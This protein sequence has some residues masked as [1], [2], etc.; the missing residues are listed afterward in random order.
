MRCSI[1]AYVLFNQV[2]ENQIVDNR[3]DFYL[4]INFIADHFDV[5]GYLVICDGTSYPYPIKNFDREYNKKEMEKFSHVYGIGGIEI[6]SDD[7]GTLEQLKQCKKIGV[8]LTK[9]GKQVS[10]TVFLFPTKYEKEPEAA[11]F[12]YPW[13]GEEF[14]PTRSTIHTPPEP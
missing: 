1:I 10:D 4:Q 8:A 7:L 2:P 11:C 6:C 9:E 13:S 14:S 5:D 3:M 12:I